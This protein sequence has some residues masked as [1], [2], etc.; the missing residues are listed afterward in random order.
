MNC[1]FCVNLIQK[2]IILAT[3]LRLR[4]KKTYGREELE[5]IT[6]LKLSFNGHLNGNCF[7]LFVF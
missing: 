7:M 2:G 4:C 3:F 6:K 5:A 1:Y